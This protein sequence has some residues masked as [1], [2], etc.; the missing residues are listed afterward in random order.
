MDGL[1]RDDL[2]VADVIDVLAM[3]AA[4]VAGDASVRSRRKRTAR[5][6]DLLLHGLVPRESA[7]Q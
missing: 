5:A 3:I 4:L 1:V 7:G 2:T 6:L